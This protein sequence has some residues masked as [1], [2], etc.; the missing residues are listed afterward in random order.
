MPKI[1]NKRTCAEI[2]RL[3]MQAVIEKTYPVDS[4]IELAMVFK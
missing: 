1:W 4:R 3:D 2:I